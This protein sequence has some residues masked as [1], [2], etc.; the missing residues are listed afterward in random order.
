MAKGFVLKKKKQYHEAI[1]ELEKGLKLRDSIWVEGATLHIIDIMNPLYEY[2]IGRC[3]SFIDDKTMKLKSLEYF[4]RAINFCEKHSRAD[5]IVKGLAFLN[6][7]KV[8]RELKTECDD[9]EQLLPN[10]EVLIR[11]SIGDINK[12]HTYF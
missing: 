12:S 10:A 4:D 2:Y 6:K 3:Y 5:H 9:F 8:C 11:G 1:V 7:R